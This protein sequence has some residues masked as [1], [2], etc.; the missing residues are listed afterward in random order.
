MLVTCKFLEHIDYLS[1][2]NTFNSLNKIEKHTNFRFLDLSLD[3]LFSNL[4]IKIAISS[5]CSIFSDFEHHTS[6][7]KLNADVFS[8]TVV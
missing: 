7:R 6:A 5:L 3:P 1:A 2:V 4:R 8:G